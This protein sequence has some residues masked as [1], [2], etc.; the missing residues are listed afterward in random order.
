MQFQ[1]RA[2]S[3]PQQAGAAGSER[4]EEKNGTEFLLEGGRSLPGRRLLEGDQVYSFACSSLI[5]AAI[6]RVTPSWGIRPFSS[7]T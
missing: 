4:I 1:Q 5:C 7:A 2:C 6:Q 3:F